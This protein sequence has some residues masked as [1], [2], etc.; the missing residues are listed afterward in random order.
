MLPKH[1]KPKFQNLS[2][3]IKTPQLNNYK[4]IRGKIEKYQ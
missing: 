1:S 2:G 4:Q 3:H